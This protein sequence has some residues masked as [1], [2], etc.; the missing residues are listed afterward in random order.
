[1]QQD[2]T[3]WCLRYTWIIMTATGM[4]QDRT[5]WCLRYTWIIMTATWIQHRTHWCTHGLLW[6][7]LEYNNTG[8][9]GV[10]MDYY[11]SH[12]N[13]T[14]Q[15]TLVFEVHMDYYWPLLDSAILRS[16]ADPLHFPFLFFSFVSL[17]VG[18]FRVSTNSPN[19]YMD[20]VIFNVRELSPC[21]YTLGNW[22]YGLIRRICF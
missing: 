7:P 8:H 2:R 9:T 17:P 5:H 18:L 11:G 3:H 14:G 21:V 20:H 4:Q 13:A 10:H 19:P 12:W 15:D 6:Q 1:M 22:V 16:P